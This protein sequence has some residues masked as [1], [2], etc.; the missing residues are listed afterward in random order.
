[1]P[2][3]VIVSFKAPAELVEQL[4]DLVRSGVFRNRSE[5]LRYALVLLVTQYR[6][7]SGGGEAGERGA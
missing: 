6:A 5:A 4:D 7:G 2:Q 3:T 1:M